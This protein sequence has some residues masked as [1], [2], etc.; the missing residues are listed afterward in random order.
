MPEA[1]RWKIA[2]HIAFNSSTE[3]NYT[4]SEKNHLPVQDGNKVCKR[5]AM[6]GSRARIKKKGGWRE[7]DLGSGFTEVA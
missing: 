2:Q 5:I 4:I 1:Q 3:S 6:I 7:R